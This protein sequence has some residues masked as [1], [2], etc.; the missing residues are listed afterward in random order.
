MTDEHP[1]FSA[2]PTRPQA[3]V[4][5]DSGSVPGGPSALT[6]TPAEATGA[7]GK[8]PRTPIVSFANQKGGVGK[9]TTVI[10]LAGCLANLGQSVLVVDL[11]PQANATSG[12]GLEKQEGTSLFQVIIGDEA[13]LDMIRPTR[14]E[15]I[16]VIPSELDMA[17][18]EIEVARMENYLQCIAGILEPV[19]AQNAY[20][21]ILLDCPPSLGILTM[22]ALAASDSV[23]VPMQCE[24]YALEGL[25]VISR[26][27]TQLRESGVKPDLDIEGILMTMFDARTNLS[28]DVVHEVNRHFH[29][30]VYN[31]VIPRNIRV[32]EA[33]SFGQPI[34]TYAPQ[35]PGA[36][37]YDL[38]AREFLERRGIT[39]P[40]VKGENRRPPRIPIFRVT[41]IDSSTPDA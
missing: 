22:N 16:H 18:S 37:A 27:I 11:D 25:T 28:T 7:V 31:T 13:T 29:D 12:L 23:V 6:D 32:G 20:D 5:N 40:K 4:D 1:P 21:F 9:T 36:V 38:F 24:Y 30:K 39:P 19:A 33:P 41:T 8:I 10:N 34:S 17:G 15:S 14:H 3:F 26:L 2:E 35:S